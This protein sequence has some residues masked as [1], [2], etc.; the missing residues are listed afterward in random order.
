[1]CGVS[2]ELGNSQHSQNG[3]ADA[4]QGYF[5]GMDTSPMLDNTLDDEAMG[6]LSVDGNQGHL[7]EAEGKHRYDGNGG[8]GADEHSAKNGQPHRGGLSAALQGPGEA[9]PGRAS[10]S[11]GL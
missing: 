4:D 5:S 11:T 1:L 10:R 6:N 2:K 7:L 9:P 8:V 3:T